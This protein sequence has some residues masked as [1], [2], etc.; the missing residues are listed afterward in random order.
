MRATS[1]GSGVIRTS[2]P[3]CGREAAVADYLAALPI[4]CNG[5][6]TRVTV[7]DRIDGGPLL[8]PPVDP[9]PPPPKVPPPPPPPPKVPPPPPPPPKGMIFEPKPQTKAAAVP[10]PPAPVDEPVAPPVEVGS[11]SVVSSPLMFTAGGPPPD[12]PP[13]PD[14]PA[15][16]PLAAVPAP[17]PPP[18]AAPASPPKVV[19]AP[20]PPVAD[21]PPFPL[22]LAGI[23]RRLLARFLFLLGLAVVG[24]VG[25]GV[26]VF[27]PPSV[28][29]DPLILWAIVAA[30]P[31]IYLLVNAAMLA[32]T[33]QDVGK[34]YAGVRVVNADGSQAT[35]MT[36]LIKRDA[37][38]LVI[39]L[40]GVGLLYW[41][42]DL[43]TLFG[44]GGRTLHDRIAGTRVV[45]A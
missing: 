35:E 8:A 16:V 3:K 7:G 2:C 25:F 43:F 15:P 6:G 12:D 27:V 36:A 4:L 37:L 44:K 19:P 42:I 39:G 9:P 41:L 21:E 1:T 23:G 38:T 24:G 26:L 18:T 33:G 14:E 5:C 11:F 13:L 22:P 28:K 32:R 34:R 17:P 40:T 45:R 20:P 30:F 10:P 29:R 31:V